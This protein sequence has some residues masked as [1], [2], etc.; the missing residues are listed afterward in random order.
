MRK[1]LNRGTS[2]Q[3]RMARR[4]MRGRTRGVSPELLAALE[5]VEKLVRKDISGAGD[6]MTGGDVHTDT[7]GFG[8]QWKRKKQE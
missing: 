6:T 1:M 2:G 4:L 7:A 8:R 5:E 3:R